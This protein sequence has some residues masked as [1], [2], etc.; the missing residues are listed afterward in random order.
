MSIV[1]PSLLRNIGSYNFDFTMPHDAVG[2]IVTMNASAKGA[3]ATTLAL[4]FRYYDDASDTY[5]DLQD[6]TA[7]TPVTVGIAAT[8]VVPVVAW[9]FHLSPRMSAVALH[10]TLRH[11]ACLVPSKLRIVA[12]VAVDTLTFSIGA[13]PTN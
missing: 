12:A 7:T 11:F 1:A 10:A 6:Y 13:R 3:G 8:A 9:E 5:R 4:T 2:V